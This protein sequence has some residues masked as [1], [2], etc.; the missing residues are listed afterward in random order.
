MKIAFVST[1]PPTQCGIATYS[2]PL[3]EG[4]DATEPGSV[5]VIGD[6]DA[7]ESNDKIKVEATF[8]RRNNLANPIL[9]AVDRNRPDIVHIQYTPDILGTGAQIY[10][11]LKGL[12]ERG[13]KSVLTMHT[14]YTL[15]SGILERKPHTMYFNN[16]L[17]KL[18]DAIVVHQPSIINMLKHHG[19]PTEKVH[20]IPHWT[21]TELKGDGTGLR[22][23]LDIPQDAPLLLFFGFIHVQKNVHTVIKAMPNILKEIPE[24]KLVIAGSIAGGT[25]YNNLYGSY[26]RRLIKSNCLEDS[27]KLLAG[28]VPQE[29]VADYYSAADIVLMPHSQ[30]YGSASGVAHQA[31][32]ARRLMLCSDSAKFEEIGLNVS[33]ELLVPATRHKLWAKEAVRL[34]KKRGENGEFLDKICNYAD[35]TSVERVVEKH[36]AL[37]K[38]LVAKAD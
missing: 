3:V 23:K 14:V 16:R 2:V 28:F 36:M 5:M 11:L 6:V 1:Y 25:W 4:I 31:L 22:E 12:R 17:G 29:E 38:S 8:K 27:V 32:A 30:K 18:S 21:S 20:M 33:P 7:E 19:V 10:G 35:E 13:I 26:I 34:L 24:A 9:E 37:Y 15:Y